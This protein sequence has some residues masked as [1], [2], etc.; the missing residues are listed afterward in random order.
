MSVNIIFSQSITGYIGREDE[1]LYNI[2]ADMARFKALTSN[3]VVIMGRKTWLSIPEKYRPLPNRHNIVLSRDLDIK[4]EGAQIF[5][6]LHDVI[7]LFKRSGD[8]WIMGGES[9]YSEGMKYADKIYQ[10]LVYDYAIGDVRAPQINSDEWAIES[11]SEIH[12]VDGLKY[13]FR[14]Y[15]RKHHVQENTTS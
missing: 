1:L 5:N 10:T 6:N 15:S 4:Y 2:K 9:V 14:N 13:Q 7:E 3:S 8:I 11:M 12:C